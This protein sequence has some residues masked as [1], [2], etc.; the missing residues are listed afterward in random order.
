MY[1]SLQCC[2]CKEHVAGFGVRLE[3]R[4]GRGPGICL[5]ALSGF[6]MQNTSTGCKDNGGFPNRFLELVQILHGS[7]LLVWLSRA[8]GCHRHQNRV[9]AE[10]LARTVGSHSRGYATMASLPMP[11]GFVEQGWSPIQVAAMLHRIESRTLR[12]RVS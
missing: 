4:E 1:L 6:R 7:L 11:T 9:W 10:S 8:H 5:G 2:C 3:N 12:R